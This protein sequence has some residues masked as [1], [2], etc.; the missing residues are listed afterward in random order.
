VGR[1]PEERTAA[2][3]G[4]P[5]RV[6]RLV[7]EA[8]ALEPLDAL[9]E[10]LPQLGLLGHEP[11]L[12]PGG[13]G[14]VPGDD[15]RQELGDRLQQPAPALGPLVGAAGLL[16]QVEHLVQPCLEEFRGADGEPV[17]HRPPRQRL[18]AHGGLQ[19]AVGPGRQVLEEELAAQPR[20]DALQGHDHAV[21][22]VLPGVAGQLLEQA[23]GALLV[24][25]RQDAGG[26]RLGGDHQQ[27]HLGALPGGL[28]IVEAAH[29]L[30]ELEGAAAMAGDL[31]PHGDGEVEV[32]TRPRE[33]AVAA[34]QR[35]QPL[36]GVVDER[37]VEGETDL[38]VAEGLNLTH[39][40]AQGSTISPPPVL[41]PA[42]LVVTG[43]GAFPGPGAGAVGRALSRVKFRLLVLSSSS[44]VL[45]V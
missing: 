37:V 11:A 15:G 22:G 14:R 13:Q 2:V 10:G 41:G 26:Q 9:L 6:Q 20:P 21:A 29:G 45:V 32:G 43:P 30:D 27:E 4:L 39:F 16:G 18:D 38:I 24:V 34:Q 8:V 35:E 44:T 31:V 23:P 25:P 28:A 19:E 3:E 5:Q 36:R 40:L 1:V 7:A 42:G 33:P 17:Q 12:E